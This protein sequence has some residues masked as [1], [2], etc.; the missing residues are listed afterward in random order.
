VELL[1]SL[2]V[3]SE[4][5]TTG[6]VR[7]VSSCWTARGLQPLIL[8][9]TVSVAN[10]T[11]CPDALQICGM[12]MIMILFRIIQQRA[13]HAASKSAP[14]VPNSKSLPRLSVDSISRQFSSS[15]TARPALRSIFFCNIPD[16]APY[17]TAQE[18]KDI[19]RLCRT[20][21]CISIQSSPNRPSPTS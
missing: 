21:I 16:Q 20:V 10:T 17:R 4:A 2:V 7:A 18:R 13:V 9:S 14:T 12:L 15:P 11:T 6:M 5:K 19:A 1:S 3:S 8:F